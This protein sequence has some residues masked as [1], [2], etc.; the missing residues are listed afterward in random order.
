MANFC[1]P[2][3]L[4]KKFITALKSGELDVEKLAD[5]SSP[6]RRAAFSKVLGPEAGKATNALFES[7]LLLKNQQAGLINWIKKLTGITP[8]VQRDMIAKVNRLDEVLQPESEQAFLADLVE[9]RLGVGVTSKEAAEIARLAQDIEKTKAAMESGGDRMDYGKARVAFGNYVSDLKNNAD[10]L[11]IKE[12]LNPANVGK[13]IS[14]LGGLTKSLKASLDNSAIFRQGWKTMFTNPKQWMSN[15]RKTYSDIVKELGGKNVMDEI[16]ADIQSRPT[17]DKMRKAKLDTGTAEEAFPSSLPEKVPGLGRL[18]KASQSAYTGFIYRQRA[19]IFDKYLEIAAKSGV[20]VTEKAQLE[21]IGKLVNSLTGRGHL[22]SLEPS[23]QWFNNIFFSPRFLKSSLDFITAHQMQKGVTPFV[24]QQAAKNLAKVVT[25]TG[26]I[27]AIANAVAPGSVEFDPR[28]SDFGK[29]RI[30][31]TRFDVSGGMASLISVL[32]REISGSSKSSTT[33]K[34]TQLDD[35]KAY[36]GPTRLSVA[37]DF[38]ANKFAPLLNTALTLAAGRDK[39]TDK[40]VNLNTQEGLINFGKL[41]LLPIPFS[42]YEELRDNPKAAPILAAMLLD[43]HG[44]G[45]NT[46]GK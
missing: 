37:G 23:A 45:S 24:R 4:T 10:T 17:Y 9:Q 39:F 13:N 2:E 14:D 29:I 31:N 44:I 18:Y 42:N 46:Y 8:E 33:G 36:K 6:E 22:G 7:K 19:D 25:G 30:G 20:D 40:P 41:L 35:P 38:T 28:S 12:R 32:A 5:M 34:I 26:A 27:L 3:V 43:L 16:Q 1:L 15:A 11:T 21:S